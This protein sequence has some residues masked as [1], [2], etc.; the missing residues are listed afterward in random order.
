MK[1]NRLSP[2]NHNY[3]KIID[4][5]AKPPEKL[6]F[7][8]KLP[9]NRIPTVAIVG[10]RKPTSY[11]KEVTTRLS[12]DLA[13]RG[14]L[15]ISGMAMGV[16]AIAHRS[17]LEVGGRTIAVL[18]NGVD[19]A[20]PASNQQLYNDILQKDS[21]II[22]EYEPGFEPRSY[23]FLERNRIVSGLADAVIITEAAIGSGTMSTAAHALEQGKDVFVVPGNITSPMSMGCNKLIKQGANP[24]AC[25]E[26]V[27]EIIAPQ[28]L[29]S[30]TQLA[31]GSN[32]NENL[33][34]ELLQSG[35]RDGEELQIKSQINP[36]E[37]SSTMTIMEI[38]GTIRHLG[39]NQWTLK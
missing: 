15:I 37:L 25:A 39:A 8:G 7:I 20:Y 28:L 27:I 13:K 23:T 35:V 4:S 17:C 31:L 36:S 18:G 30:Q 6:Y 21:A 11:G 10:T 32:P 14:I 12:T 24:I 38:N 34:I 19:I 22:S 33:I 3:L 9:D 26:D 5:I 1:I 29:N 2:H 16:D